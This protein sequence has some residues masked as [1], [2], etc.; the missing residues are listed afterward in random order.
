[1]TLRSMAMIFVASGLVLAGL[2]GC[3]SFLPGKGEFK[4]KAPD[5]VP[6]MSVEEA[7]KRSVEGRAPTPPVEPPSS[8]AAGLDGGDA[9][10][11]APGAVSHKDPVALPSY[12]SGSVRVT[13]ST[14]SPVRSE[15]RILRV[16]VAPWEDREG[17]LHDQSYVWVTVDPGR[18]MIDHNRRRIMQAFQPVLAPRKAN[19]ANVAIPA[20]GATPPSL[21]MPV[22]PFAKGGSDVQ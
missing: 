3:A 1:M 11:L 10:L 18:W 12:R 7:Y 16:W 21:P 14:G 2:T 4:C 8:P 15:A 5:G 19:A 22:M 9:D 20:A 13:P 17:D 6:C